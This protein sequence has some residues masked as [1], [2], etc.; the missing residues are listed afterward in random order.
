MDSMLP[1]PYNVGESAV[2]LDLGDPFVERGN[3]G[4]AR[5]RKEVEFRV[6]QPEASMIHTVP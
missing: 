1:G 5:R 6:R 3:R 2:G 4:K